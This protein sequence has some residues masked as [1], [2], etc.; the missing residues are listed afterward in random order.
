ML[1]ILKKFLSFRKKNKLITTI[2]KLKYLIQ[3]VD[4]I[5]LYSSSFRNTNDDFLERDIISYIDQLQFILRN[6]LETK[7]ISIKVINENNYTYTTYSFWY[8]NAGMILKDNTFLKEWLELSLR[9]MQWAEHAK[10]DFNNVNS[11]VNS[12]KLSPYYLNISNIVNSMIEVIT[13]K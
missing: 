11:T 12:R 1:N 3:E 4:N 9:F 6:S 7:I 8:S 5:N 10:K 2:D 13:K